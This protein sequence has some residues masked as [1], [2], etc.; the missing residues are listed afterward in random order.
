MKSSLKK[1]ISQKTPQNNASKVAFFNDEE[2]NK[3]LI[4][5]NETEEDEDCFKERKVKIPKMMS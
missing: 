1:Q 5:I 4:K 3:A 2:S